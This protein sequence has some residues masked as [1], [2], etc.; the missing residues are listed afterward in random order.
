M[1]KIKM[2]VKS[3]TQVG[4]MHNKITQVSPYRMVP[5]Y[6]LNKMTQKDNKFKLRSLMD[7]KLEML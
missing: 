5:K 3:T 2:E 4:K 1:L 7:K 6:S